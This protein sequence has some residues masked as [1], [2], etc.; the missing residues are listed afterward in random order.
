MKKALL[1]IGAVVAVIAIAAVCLGLYVVRTPE[2]ALM[3][4]IKDVK[5][6]GMRGLRPHLTVEAQEKIDAVSSLADNKM[7][8]AIMGLLGKN[9][10]VSVLKEEMQ[11]V[12]WEVDD[13]MKGSHNA[14]VI[15]K[16]NYDDRLIG[17]IALS[18]VQKS[19]GWKIDGLELP[20]FDEINW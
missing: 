4:T 20:K 14:E 7:V 6:S 9:D 19:D 16:F 12:Q 18:M 10:Y 17:T 5:A 13:I 15:V 1:I 8:G 3:Q 11:Q 2:Y